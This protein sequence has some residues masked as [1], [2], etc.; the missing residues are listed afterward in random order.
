MRSQGDTLQIV[1]Q[2]IV[3]FWAVVT[4][5]QNANGFGFSVEQAL[6]EL[7]LLKQLFVLKSDTPEILLEWEK[8]VIKYQVLGKQVHDTRLVSAMIVHQISHLLTFNLD[9]FKRFS[10]IVA[11]DP[12]KVC[13]PFQ[14]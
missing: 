9:D 13:S 3:E 11:I 6:Q 2:N 8:L 10:E 1:P 5:P 4:R 7:T 12:R 14:P